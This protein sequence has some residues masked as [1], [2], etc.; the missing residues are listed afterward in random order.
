MI[1]TAAG[2]AKIFS[3]GFSLFSGWTVWFQTKDLWDRA[4]VCSRFPAESSRIAASTN[5]SLIDCQR[6]QK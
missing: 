2:I 4:A 5:P 1:N 3:G 6:G